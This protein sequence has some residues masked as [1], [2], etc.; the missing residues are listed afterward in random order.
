MNFLKNNKKLRIIILIIFF[1]FAGVGMLFSSVLVAMRLHLTDVEGS[2]DSRNEFFNTVNEKEGVRLPVIQKSMSSN[3][4][5]LDP[6]IECKIMT[7]NSVLPEN[8]Q[9]ILDTYISTKSSVIVENMINA[10]VLVTENNISFIKEKLAKCDD[11]GNSINSL[12]GNASSQSIF[13]WVASTEWQTLRDALVKDKDVILQASVD[14]GVSA[15]LIIATV[16]SEQFRFFTSNRES[17][18]RYFEPMKV[19]GNGTKFSYGVAGVKFGTAQ[20]IESNLKNNKSPFYLGENYEGIFNYGNADPD[21]ELMGRLTDPKNHYYSYMYTAIFLKQIMHQWEEAGY[22]IN[23]RPE[24]LATLFNLGFHKSS[25]KENPE[26]GGSTI[27][28]N[29]RDY[30]FGGLSYEF[31]YSGEL[32]EIFPIKV[33]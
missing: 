32:Q 33:Q 5:K 9:R 22:S 21:T 7:I 10:I 8:G 27:T 6:V 30:T 26:V 23:D 17:Y 31:Y 15:R 29:D 24:V 3:F 13:S 16:I 20:L 25:P 1:G 2:I 28:I 18:K 12:G 4:N 19:L 14:S 11:L